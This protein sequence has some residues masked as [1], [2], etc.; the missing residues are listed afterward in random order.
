MKWMLAIF[1][2]LILSQFSIGQ[3]KKIDQLEIL[4]D[5]GY[6]AKVIRKANK[7]IADPEFD[8]SALPAY[9]K[10]ISTF[11]MANDERWLKRHKNAINEAIENYEVFAEHSNY[12]NYVHA[13]Y[14]EISSI[15]TYLDNLGRKLEEL[16]YRD[17]STKLFDF[18]FKY[19]KSIKGKPDKHENL[20]NSDKGEK[21]NSTEIASADR[22]KLVVYAKSLVGIKY[23]WA[24]S[25]ESG[26]DCSGFT[27]YVCKKYGIQLARTASG[28]LEGAKKI[29]LD[30]AQKGDLVFFGSGAKIT[31]VG[32]VVSNKGDELSMVHASTSKGVIVTNIEKSTYWKPK[33]KAA[34]SYLD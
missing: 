24:G 20:N 33:L 25:T 29:K 30:N 31:H 34:G 32:L 1:S 23:V 21:P 2:S 5:Q 28:Q 13:H 6:Y 16:G 26:F 11:R 10:S 7:L 15:K 3:D 8:Y 9:Y 18:N 4:Y 19:L 14:Y 12:S 22:E 27:S 17:E